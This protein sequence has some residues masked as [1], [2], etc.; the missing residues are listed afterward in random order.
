L[1]RPRR[2]LSGQPGRVVAF[3]LVRPELLSID[4]KIERAAEHLERLKRELSDYYRDGG[5][6]LTGYFEIENHD[7][8][9]GLQPHCEVRPL[10]PGLGVTIG[11]FV[12][13]LHSALDHLA[14]Q[15]VPPE[16]RNRLT[17]FPILTE[18]PS[19]GLPNISGA[20]SDEVRAALAELQPWLPDGTLDT[21]HELFGLQE[22]SNNDKH[23]RLTILAMDFQIPTS[24]SG[25]PI[26]GTVLFPHLDSVDIDDGRVTWRLIPR[27]VR[28]EAPATHFVWQ[29]LGR[30][31][32][33][34]TGGAWD[35]PLVPALE[36]IL[37]AVRDEV[38]PR[39]VPFTLADE[40]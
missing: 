17:T 9:I 13:C 5:P 8:Q 38:V 2:A 22:L 24:Y 3:G 15:L 11:D 20:A 23:R 19:G 31:R 18:R 25:D 1:S 32:V 10:P 27:S 37:E 28:R 21:N 6:L 34:K 29:L 35:F 7:G 39:L 26:V 33:L 36:A 16:A 12:H 14:W 30:I 40:G 4:A